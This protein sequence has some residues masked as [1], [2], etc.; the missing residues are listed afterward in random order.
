MYFTLITITT[1]GF[2]DYV[3]GNSFAKHEDRL[4]AGLKMAVAMLTTLAG[5]SPSPPRS[6]SRGTKRE[7]G[8]KGDM[9]H[10]ILLHQKEV[11]GKQGHPLTLRFYNN[12]RLLLHQLR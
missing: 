2:G 8:K 12:K 11:H 3:P 5:E 1:I 4:T 6:S 9:L 10:F 7:I